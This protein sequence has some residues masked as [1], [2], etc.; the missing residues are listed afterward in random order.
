[1]TGYGAPRRRPQWKRI[2]AAAALPAIAAALIL[3][4]GPEPILQDPGTQSCIAEVVET[5]NSQL[6]VLGSI[7]FG[8]QHLKVRMP[9][10]SIEPAAN[11]M[12]AQLELDKKFK[13][14]D[15]AVVCA[16][17]GRRPDE[18][19]TARDH[20][21]FGFQA[22]FFAAFAAFLCQFAG[23]TGLMAILTF[24]ISCLAIWKIM[25]PAVIA[26]FSAQWAAF[27]TAAALTA[28]ITAA[29]AGSAKTAACAFAGSM[30][31]IAASLA[32]VTFFAD[33]T[34]TTGAT[35][36]FAQQLLY[37]GVP[38]VDLLDLF[39]GAAV[40]ASS[41]AV[42]DLA[43]DVS[44]GVAEVS[45]RNPSLGFKELFVSGRRIG[46]AVIGTMTTTLL[47]AYS[48]G[49]LTLLVVFAVMGTKP[50]DMLNTP[51][52]GAEVVKTLA[53]SFG[54]AL[55]APFTALAAAW[56]FSA[57]RGGAGD[58]ILHGAG[59]CKTL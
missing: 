46:K 33:A 21:R 17:P 22:A 51:L 9:D 40:L 14:G 25:I 47:F 8:T 45:R 57:K 24:F 23:F 3:A 54:L 12:R 41:G 39:T 50:V 48:G 53:G 58:E 26:G 31:G 38:D 13:P 44:A 56:I 43:M 4:P 30:L 16:P 29:V 6:R 59:Q 55:T 27:W 5:D 7:D 34:N 49:Y 19:L 15:R 10:G 52:V 37:S 35:M 11:E 28:M 20:W 1:M 18:P 36:P 32:L 2:A 42:A